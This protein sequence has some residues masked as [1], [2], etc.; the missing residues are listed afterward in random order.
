[1]HDLGCSSVEVVELAVTLEDH[2]D[3][4]DLPFE[5]LLLTADGRYVD[6]LTVGQLAEFVSAE[7]RR[8]RQAGEAAV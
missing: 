1:V 8:R 5:E 4:P 7:L 6:D 3:A 2:F